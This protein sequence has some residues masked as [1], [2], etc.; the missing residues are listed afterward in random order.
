[1]NN[2]KH[3]A[4]WL[5]APIESVSN[6]HVFRFIDFLRARRLKPKTINC[7]LQSIRGFYDWLHDEQPGNMLN[8]V[9]R[10]YALKESKPLPKGPCPPNPL[11]FI[12]LRPK[13]M[14]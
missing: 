6:S 3:F 14:I 1:M 13:Q 12:A 4:I 2:L 11:G 5:P 10:G 8:P 7:Y 9:K